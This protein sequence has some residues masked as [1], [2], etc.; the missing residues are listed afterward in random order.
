MLC[1]CVRKRKQ[2]ASLYIHIDTQLHTF[3]APLLQLQNKRN[4]WIEA[5]GKKSKRQQ[6]QQ[7]L[8]RIGIIAYTEY[9]AKN[10]KNHFPKQ[11]KYIVCGMENV[12][13]M[14]SYQTIISSWHTHI[15]TPA[16]GIY[17]A[18]NTI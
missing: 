6:Q 8:E 14:I 2:I 4:T 7:Q 10:M 15:H 3:T 12:L 18:Q 16:T 11:A 5:A 13:Y 1:H 9:T 17:T